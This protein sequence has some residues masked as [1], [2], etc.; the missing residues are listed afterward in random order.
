MIHWIATAFWAVV[1]MTLSAPSF[2]QD[3]PALVR[4]DAVDRIASTLPT[5]SHTTKDHAANSIAKLKPSPQLPSGGFVLVWWR[6][7]TDSAPYTA[8]VARRF[9]TDGTPIDASE[10]V[11]NTSP[12]AN[13]GSFNAPVAAGLNDGSFVVVWSA[14][15]VDQAGGYGILSRRFDGGGVPLDGSEVVVNAT[16]TGNQ[17]IPSIA[18]LEGGGYV[19]A[20]WSYGPGDDIGV[21]ARR[22]ATNGTPLDAS[23]FLVNA[24]TEG[25]QSNPSVAALPGGGFVIAWDADIPGVTDSFDIFVRRFDANGTPIEATETKVNVTDRFL[26]RYPS[27]TGLSDGGFVVAYESLT[28][29]APPVPPQMTVLM[30]RFSANGTPLDSNDARVYDNTR[31]DHLSPSL[32]SLPDGGFAVTSTRF[33]QLDAATFR[34]TIYLRRFLAD[35]TPTSANSFRVG[36]NTTAFQYNASSGLIGDGNVL[37]VV[38]MQQQ[39]PDLSIAFQRLRLSSPPTQ[40]LSAVLPAARSVATGQTATAFGTILNASATTTATGCGLSLPANFP[41]TFQYQTTNA[42]N[43]PSGSPNTPAD[44]APGSAQGFVLGVTPNVDLYAT[45]LGIVFSCSNMPAAGLNTLLLSSSP[46]PTPDMVA[47]GSTPSGDG[48]SSI[49]GPSG[50]TFWAAAVVNIGAAGQIMASVDDNGQSLAAEVTICQSNPA[51]AACVNPPTFASSTTFESPANGV[52]TFTIKVTGTGNVPFD[53]ANNRLFLRF[54]S[55]DGVSRGATSVA[56]RTAPPDP[57]MSSAR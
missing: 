17:I 14:F 44:I 15:G 42:A 24:I 49:P 41:G 21:F 34:G 28:I 53:P 47:I 32:V 11:V 46:T 19:V 10:I 40:I 7:G 39:A 57:P 55:E 13:S 33:E 37:G 50:T 56:V 52:S 5:V 26:Q 4:L 30:R 43:A 54:K 1:A 27:V 9:T 6:G 36:T 45:E 8:I 16:R 22:F 3:T 23:E 51:T 20:W 12:Q 29:N 31:L 38:W 25:Q 35:G 2:A 48:I 18:P